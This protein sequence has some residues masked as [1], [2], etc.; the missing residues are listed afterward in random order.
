MFRKYIFGQ[1]GLQ[2]TCFLDKRR[3]IPELGLEIWTLRRIQGFETSKGVSTH[4]TS[5]CVGQ[6]F[7]FF[8]IV[9]KISINTKSVIVYIYKND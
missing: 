3:G 1:S 5:I 6:S 2:A 8:M 9:C 4:P 7:K